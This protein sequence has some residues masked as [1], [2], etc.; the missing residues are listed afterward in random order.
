VGESRLRDSEE[1]G[2]SW[3]ND[4]T[5]LKCLGEVR[6][7]WTYYWADR[8][9]SRA[10]AAR[11][12]KTLRKHVGQLFEVCQHNEEWHTEWQGHLAELDAW[13][14]AASKPPVAVLDGARF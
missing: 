10:A 2:D 7:S 11:R 6:Y 3:R 5:V 8:V 4:R 14:L 1:E 13:L 12:E 9:V